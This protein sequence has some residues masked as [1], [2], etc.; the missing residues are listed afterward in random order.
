MG[1]CLQKNL[2]GICYTHDSI[3]GTS[4]DKKQTVFQTISP[5]GYWF[6][7]C[8]FVGESTYNIHLQYSAMGKLVWTNPLVEHHTNNSVILGTLA[9][10]SDTLLKYS[11]FLSRFSSSLLGISPVNI[12]NNV[13]INYLNP[14]LGSHGESAW[15]FKVNW[16]Q[17]E[18]SWFGPIGFILF[19]N[20]IYFLL[21]RRGS[22]QQEIK[23]LLTVY[24][25]AICAMLAWRP[26]N[27]RYFTYSLHLRAY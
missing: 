4:V 17:L 1:S 20:F 25:I 24:L 11:I 26:F 9:N 19:L 3:L 15:S 23:V 10:S 7:T 2:P 14:L 6:C 18:D 27:D 21:R 5:T 12:I 22:N 13:W 8:S 16:E